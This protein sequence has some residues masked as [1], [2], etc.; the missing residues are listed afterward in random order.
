[1]VDNGFGARSKEYEKDALVQK[2]ASEELLGLLSIKGSEAVLDL[3]CGPGHVTRKIAR[4]TSGR[5]VGADISE[6][7]IKGGYQ[8][9]EQPPQRRLPA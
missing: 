5:V 9:R 1:M 6:G 4:I 3:G 8:C 2:C 7:M